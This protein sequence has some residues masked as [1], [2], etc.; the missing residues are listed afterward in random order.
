MKDG[1]NPARPGFQQHELANYEAKNFSF[2]ARDGVACIT[3]QWPFRRTSSNAVTGVIRFRLSRFPDTSRLR[4]TYLA[5]PLIPLS[6]SPTI[7]TKVPVAILR[8]QL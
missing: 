6:E 1:T 8:A 3:L 7:H 4:G 2:K 5:N